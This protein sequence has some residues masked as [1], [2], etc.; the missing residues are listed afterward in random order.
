MPVLHACS[1]HASS[2]DRGAR[3]LQRLVEQVSALGARPM[4]QEGFEGF[5]R[6]AHELF[7]EAEREVLGEAL[8]R[9]DADLAHVEIERQR[10]HRVLDSAHRYTTAVGGV[11]AGRTLYRC[12][13]E[14]AVSPM[15]LRAGIV[16]GHWTP[17]AAREASRVVAQMT[18]RSR[19]SCASLGNMAPSKSS[20]D[21]LPK[22][23]SARWEAMAVA[24]SLDGSDGADEGRESS[25]EA[26]ATARGGPR[27]EGT[28]GLSGGALCDAVV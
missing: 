12:A 19:A 9:L 23:L 15:E 6:E 25:G 7:A 20:L 14:R 28:G 21:R 2:T 8:E 26:R 11:Q 18:P 27:C 24:V 16:E 10:H 13:G 17:L 22:G 5:E 1:H 3:A 4:A